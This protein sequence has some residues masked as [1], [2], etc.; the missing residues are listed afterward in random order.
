MDD[1]LGHCAALKAREQV[2][3]SLESIEHRARR[4]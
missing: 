3:F 1:P 2:L 4:V